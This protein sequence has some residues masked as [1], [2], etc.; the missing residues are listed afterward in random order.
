MNKR[1]ERCQIAGKQISS[2]HDLVDNG[3]VASLIRMKFLG[4]CQNNRVR[5][6]GG[7]A[8]MPLCREGCPFYEI[9]KR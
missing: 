4:K 2:A 5:E 1:V 7:P 6:N 9:V 8:S 3:L